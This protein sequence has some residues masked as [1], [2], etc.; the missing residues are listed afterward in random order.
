MAW[1]DYDEIATH[2]ASRGKAPR[3]RAVIPSESVTPC[4][5]HCRIPPSRSSGDFW[6]DS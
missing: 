1:Q 2:R 3:A 5:P 6:L 4:A